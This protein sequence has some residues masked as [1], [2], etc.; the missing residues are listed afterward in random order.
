MWGLP[1]GA[2]YDVTPYSLIKVF[3]LLEWRRAAIFRTE[4]YAENAE[5]QTASDPEDGDSL[6][7]RNAS[8]ILPN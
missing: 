6:L 2:F 5:Q 8:K 1:G 3:W 4:E 7:F